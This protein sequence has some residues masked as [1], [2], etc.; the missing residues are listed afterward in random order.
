MVLSQVEQNP[1]Q[2]GP[3]P[4]RELAQAV[5][6]ELLARPGA[7]QAEVLIGSLPDATG[8]AVLLR[9][10]WHNLIANALKFSAGAESPRIVIGAQHA[11]TECF[12]R[13]QDNGVGFDASQASRLYG[14]FQRLHEPSEFP[15][16]GVGLSIVKRV[17]HRHQG[18][19]GA[20]SRPGEGAQF[21]FVLPCAEPEAPADPPAQAAA[22]HEA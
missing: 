18:R 13:V 8:D 11:G 3:V 5:A 22:L 6:D 17:V 2:S 12:Y 10:V 7:I 9:Q 14:V 4:M 1:L 21:W 20:V 19:V 16:T 15:G